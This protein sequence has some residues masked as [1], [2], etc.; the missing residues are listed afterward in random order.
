MSS[1]NVHH[2]S[3]VSLEGHFGTVALTIFPLFTIALGNRKSRY[4][5]Q[6]AAAVK[7]VS[8]LERNL[9]I[10]VCNFYIALRTFL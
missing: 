10:T 1:C 8:Q 6:F 5:H 9:A 3:T 2:K 4:S 7:N